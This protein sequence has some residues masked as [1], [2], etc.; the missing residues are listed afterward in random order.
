MDIQG[1]RY[2]NHA[3]VPTTSPHESPDILPI[4]NGSIWKI[5]GGTPLLARWTEDFD[6]GYE[7]NWWYIIRKAPFELESL[8]SKVRK[9]IRQ[10]LKKVVV[11]IV[12]TA[13]FAEELAAV[14]NAACGGYSN[15]T[16]R[17]ATPE[18]F[19]SEQEKSLEC[20]GAFSIETGRLIG[21]M[22]CRRRSDCIE[23]VTAKYDPEFLNL[24]ASD[25]I[26]FTVFEHYLNFEKYRYVSSG[27]RTI[28]HIT[29]AQEYKISTFGCTKAFCKLRLVYNP[30]Y[31]WIV[32]VLYPFRKILLKFDR[33]GI[34][35]SV[36]SI[37][38][39]ENIC[40]SEEKI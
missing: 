10:A 16:G 29:N 39:M 15:F 34:I 2:Y 24:R 32:K 30:K 18:D 8:D 33:I 3:A 23:T 38:K 4:E 14:F 21:Y 37:L 27:A 6:C 25:A 22:T 40:R 19:S 26:H 9:H 11:K 13:C 5:D 36:N 20:W 7:T 28:N 12:D 35:H 1:W 31:K 17:L